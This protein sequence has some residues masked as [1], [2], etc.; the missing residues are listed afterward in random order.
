M[1]TRWTVSTSRPYARSKAR[2]LSLGNAQRLGLAKALHHPQILV[3]DEPVN[4]LDPAG[5]VEIREL[6]VG[7]ARRRVTILLSSH[8]LSEVT[9][10][11]TRIGVLHH[12]R[13]I[14][15]SIPPGCTPRG[16]AGVEVGA[17]DLDRA[18]EVLRGAEFEVRPVADA[19]LVD[20]SGRAPPRT[21]RPRWSPAASRR[22]GSRSWRKTSRATSCGSSGTRRRHH[23]PATAGTRRGGGRGGQGPPSVV[24]ATSG[25]LGGRPGR[26][27]LHVRA[28]GPGRARVNGAAGHQ[29]QG[30]RARRGRPA[31]LTLVSQIVAVGGMLF[32]MIL[33]WLFG[34]E[35]SDRTAK[36]LLALPTSRAAVVLAKL[37]VA[38]G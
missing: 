5:V 1:T 18:A 10:V 20:G 3:L 7:L 15:G 30:S 26:G 14:E 27:V 28:A 6:L 16:A 11:A 36:D 4:G 33:I 24:L 25:L 37:V 2:T 23:C 32:G 31:Y 12:G 22:L 13:L 9:R 21:S 19:L 35:F 17:R 38:L 29:A 34:R 8:L